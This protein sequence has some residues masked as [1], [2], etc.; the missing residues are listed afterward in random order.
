[1][2]LLVKVNERWLADVGFGDSFVEP[3]SLD[4]PREQIQRGVGY[5][6]EKEGEHLTVKERQPGREWSSSYQF[7]LQPRALPA[8]AA[9]C[10]WQQ[11]APE[12]HFTQKLICSRA[13]PDGRITLS[14]DRLIT[15]RKEKREERLLDARERQ[16][17][18]AEQFGITV[19][20]IPQLSP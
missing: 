12:S 1:M 18:L 5:K 11:T 4:D 9:M 20:R 6:I 2:A 17:V 3:L 7:T 13:T 8:F 14:D 15:T 16:E 19:G 10:R